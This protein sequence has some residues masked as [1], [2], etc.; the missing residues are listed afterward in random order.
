MKG[1]L[2]KI[3]DF[4]NQKYIAVTGV[5]SSQPDAANHIFNKFKNAD[6]HVF[7][8][9]PKAPI[10][11]NIKAYPNLSSIGQK[12]DGVVVASPP[13]SAQ[14]IVEECLNLGIN[15]I[16]FHSSINQGS[17]DQEV[18]DFAE[19]KGMDVIRTG[20]PLMY[21]E[22]VDFPHRCIKWILHLTGKVPRE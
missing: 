2:E 14:P 18:A 1:H 7:A 4:V 17:L 11:E 21:I 10:V 3:K 16:W 9:N 13:S 19:E 15:R 12:I 8:I 5:S 20:C 22:P 6:Y